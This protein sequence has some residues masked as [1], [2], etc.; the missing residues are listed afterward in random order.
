MTFSCFGCF[1][2]KNPKTRMKLKTRCFLFPNCKIHQLPVNH[3]PSSPSEPSPVISQLPVN[4]LRHLPTTAD[5]CKGVPRSAPAFQDLLTVLQHLL[6]RPVKILRR[7]H[8]SNIVLLCNF[9]CWAS[10]RQIGKGKI[11]TEGKDIALLGY[12]SMVQNCLRAHSL[13]S[14]LGLDASDAKSDFFDAHFV[15]LFGMY[16]FVPYQN[17]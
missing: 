8:S 3:L 1:Q 5:V 17:V 7:S 14:K 2:L 9:P 16:E 12:G 10:V 15:G 6:R 11:L 13:L 4:H